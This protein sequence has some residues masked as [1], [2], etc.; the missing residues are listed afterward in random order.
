LHIENISIQNI[1]SFEDAHFSFDRYNVIVGANNVGKTNLIRVL[2]LLRNA[3][4]LDEI[5]LPKRLKLNDGK[6]SQLSITFHFNDEEIQLILQT[7]FKKIINQKEFPDSLKIL[8][9]K[10]NWVDLVSDNARP[11]HV[12]YRFK[13]DLTII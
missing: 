8:E 12:I 1:Y 4:I 6:T 5:R 3:A 13:N 7:F 2:N 10:I 11:I 9:V